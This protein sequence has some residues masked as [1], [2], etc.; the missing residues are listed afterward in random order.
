MFNWRYIFRLISTFFVKFRTIIIIGIA[1]GVLIFFAFSLLLP[2]LGSSKSQ[3]IGI[4]GRFT[5][6]SLPSYILEEIGDGLTSVN[7][8][9]DVEPNLASSWETPDR[10][11][12]WIFT[13][14]ENKEWQDGTKVSS[15]S[16]NYQ[17]SDL[18]TE[19][20][21]EKTIVFKLENPHSPFPGVVAKPIFK[22]G[23]LGT[24]NWKVKKLSL[25]GGFVTSLTLID[26]AKNK[27]IYKFY[28]TE[29]RTKLAFRL[30]EV[31]L[32][33]DIHNPKP[34]DTWKKLKIN[35]SSNTSEYV[36][37]FLNTQDP[38]LSDKTVRQAL[39]YGIDKDALSKDRA[40]SPISVNSWAYN[41]QVKPYNFD[42]EKAKKDI[43]E[44]LSIN[45][46]SSAILLPVAEKIAKN[47]EDLG[48]KVNIQV[49]SSIPSDYQALLAIFDIPE[50]P[51]QYTFW[52]STQTATNITKF[53]NP[54]ID[55]L[56]E[57]GRAELNLEERKKIYLDFQRFLVEDSPAIFLYYPTTYTIN[58]N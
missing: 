16:I 32:I 26:K 35:S 43:K 58:R 3:K 12:T 57:D 23:L 13:L 9:G 25:S 49:F 1:V 8:S 17:F 30:G 56:L 7:E 4:T 21:D 39:S 18:I 11:R 28:P 24:G 15:Q 19:K 29:D 5:A 45:L 36:A 10:G 52:H 53:S 2:A 47:W 48:I 51:D 27:K 20:P 31:D 34:L 50:D 33:T 38:D 55:K 42:P 22:K 40:I 37:V 44:G 46:S 6:D 41:P 54:R 14:T